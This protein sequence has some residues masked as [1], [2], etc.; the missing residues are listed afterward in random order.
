MGFHGRGRG[1][2]RG[3]AD[4]FIPDHHFHERVADA[5]ELRRKRKRRGAYFCRGDHGHGECEANLGI[6]ER[7]LASVA[8]IGG[9][10]PA[11][12][13]LTILSVGPITRL[14]YYRTGSNDDLRSFASQP[15]LLFKPQF[16]TSLRHARPF[17]RWNIG[18]R[19][20]HSICGATGRD[21]RRHLE[22]GFSSHAE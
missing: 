11:S 7:A 8:A 9:Y 16:G 1:G 22:L 2:I 17:V 14:F 19:N 12:W 18:G 21:G 6:A 3:L 20:A 13:W 5:C 10:G 15:V 4:P